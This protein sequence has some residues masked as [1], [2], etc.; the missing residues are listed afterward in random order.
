MRAGGERAITTLAKAVN[1]SRY[2]ARRIISAV[3]EG[4]EE[5][6][7]KRQKR[8]DAVSREVIDEFHEFLEE[9]QISR[10]C[11]GQTKSVGYGKREP[12]YTVAV[13]IQI[14]IQIMKML[15]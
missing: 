2:F 8:R 11:P 3:D 13:V 6:L 10:N 12:L 4:T 7:M 9:P 5:E 15:F 14:K 1:C